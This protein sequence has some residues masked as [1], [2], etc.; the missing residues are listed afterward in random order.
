MLGRKG[1]PHLFTL[2]A[3]TSVR[4]RW[5]HRLVSLP[6][7]VISYLMREGSDGSGSHP[8]VPAHKISCG[9][10][11]PVPYPPINGGMRNVLQSFK[12]GLRVLF[13]RL[14]MLLQSRLRLRRFRLRLQLGPGVALRGLPE[15]RRRHG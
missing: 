12:L 2:S 13:V 4:V 14:Q 11:N 15:L 7:A 5:I 1:Q 10:G 3:V 6:P 9:T 8:V